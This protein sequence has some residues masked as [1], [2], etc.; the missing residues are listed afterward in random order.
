ML[1]QDRLLVCRSGHLITE[2]L[3]ARPDLR[4]L[5]ALLQAGQKGL[6]FRRFGKRRWHQNR[7][8]QLTPEA[9]LRLTSSHYAPTE[10]SK[11]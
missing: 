9:Q 3:T 10:S 8:L 5:N 2:H 11:P 4:R 1:T 7:T 6:I